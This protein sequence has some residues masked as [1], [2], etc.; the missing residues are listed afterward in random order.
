MLLLA[1]IEKGLKASSFPTYRIYQE[2]TN[3]K[4]DKLNN[5]LSFSQ[6]CRI[7]SG[8]KERKFSMRV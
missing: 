3:G 6:C 2:T 7:H 8:I 5:T 1:M 4:K